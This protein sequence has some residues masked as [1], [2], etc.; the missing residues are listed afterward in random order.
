LVMVL[1]C[2]FVL[3][4]IVPATQMSRFEEYRIQCATNLSHLGRAM[5]IY[6]NDYDDELPRSGGR[7]STWV[8]IIPD[9]SAYNRYSAYGLSADGSGGSANIS[10]CFYLLVKYAEVTPGTFICPGDAGTT[11]F[12]LSDMAGFRQL[13]DLWDFGP[14]PSKH[15][16]YAYHMPFGFYALTTSS[17]PG[18]A[19]AADRNPWMSSPA[20]AAKQY[21]GPFHPDGLDEHKKYAN[22]IAH[23]EEGQ[24]VLFLDTHVGFEERSFCGINDDNIYTYWD[25]GD[26]R[27]GAPPV[28]GSMPADRMDSLLVHDP[29]T[30]GSTTITKEPE[31][32]DSNDLKQTSI[33]ATLDSPLP[34]YQNV[35]WCST[36]Q[37]AWD[38]LKLY[39][40]GEPVEVIGA[41]ELA[42]RLNAAEFSDKDIENESYFATAGLLGEGIIEEIQD[43]ME[44]LFPS[45]PAPVFD[46]ING[47]PLETIIAY[48]YL[49]ADIQFEY[50]FYISN[51]EFDFQDSN[52]TVSKVKSFCT[53]SDADS[54][55]SVRDQVDI[56]YY[57]PGD[58][59]IEAEFAVDLC[60]YTNPYQVV[61]ACVP[62]QENLGKTVDL[63]ERKIS[64]FMQDPNYEQM[65]KLKP[66]IRGGRFGEQPADSLIVPDMF[67]KL[68]HH[69]AELEGKVI[70]NQ[71]WL[72]Q[73]YIMGK[74][75]QI[76]DFALGRTGRVLKLD[77]DIVVTSATSVRRFD[78]NKPFLIYIKKRGPSASPFFVMWVD[79]AEL[80]QESVFEGQ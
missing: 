49:N 22:A 13:L 43:E 76:T 34:E 70:G 38:I 77:E 15:C 47:L 68:T 65:R 66:A 54:T 60:K 8:P 5:L 32:I 79:N 12:Q 51:Y 48:S 2:L 6:A 74:A 75:M 40:I 44:Q 9:W 64:E 10:S 31:A 39:I 1:M 35:I 50:P 27:V 29:V 46:D 61:L 71:P 14:E 67:Y 18:M 57:Q 24:N 52:G 62:Q 11:E 26:I 23:E 45:E 19:V 4:V 59:E 16:S 37:M 41:E 25:G 69:F 72:D 28:L 78:F 7:N 55:D 17:E 63:V 3:A 53:L 20:A 30:P 58:Q 21:P 80:M 73:G 56:L 36:F 33:I 42:G